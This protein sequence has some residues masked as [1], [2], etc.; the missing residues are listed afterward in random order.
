MSDRCALLFPGQGAYVP[1][2]FRSLAPAEPLVGEVLEGVDRAAARAG[3]AAVSPLLLDPGSPS[4]G[5]LVES[6]PPDLHLAIFAAEIA[7]FRLATE[8]CGLRPDV[9]VGHSFGELVALTAAGVYDVEQ[10]A[11]LVMARDSAFAACPP[12]R[13]GMLALGL[14]ASRTSGLLGA[15]G[16]WQICV[17]AD[18]GPRQCVVSGPE[19]PLGRVRKAAEAIGVGATPLPVPYPFHNP[20]LAPVAREFADRAAA[21]GAGP[22]RYRVYSA[23]LGRTLDGAEDTAA[24]VAAHLVRPT[25]FVDA[26]RALHADGVGTFVECGARGVLTDLV[27]TIVPGITAIA[28]L[29]RRGTAEE[30]LGALR[31]AGD[32]SVPSQGPVPK[33]LPA[34]VR[35]AEPVAPDPDLPEHEEII[36][37]LQHMYA[38]SL[39]YPVDVLTPDADL[40]ADLGVD[41]I[42]QTEL[43][44]RAASH[45]DRVPPT[46][47]R[48][49]SNYGSLEALAELLATLPVGEGHQVAEP[50]R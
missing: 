3:R 29:R 28:P 27:G 5:E 24:L 17:A 22:A 21:L 50:I 48:R 39:G 34:A 38:E 49:I 7:L 32:V 26:V 19:Q 23:I 40:D 30:I 42:K 15:L 33:P 25:R 41:S 46:E 45:Y 18:N 35:A 11:R 13:G 9:L 8:R 36:A 6:S 47:G 4:L 2:V 43:F 37:F 16:E 12:E 44:A 14:S 20:C 1:G 31:G 10:G